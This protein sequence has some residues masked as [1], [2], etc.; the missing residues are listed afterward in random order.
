[1]GPVKLKVSTE[2]QEYYPGSVVDGIVTVEV[3]TVSGTKRQQEHL[4]VIRS[5]KKSAAIAAAL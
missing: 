3:A 5:L 4:I 2:Q 1:M